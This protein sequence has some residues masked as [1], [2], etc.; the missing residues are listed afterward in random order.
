M[1]KFAA[2]ALLA[3]ISTPSFA[4]EYS[5]NTVLKRGE[6]V[7]ISTPSNETKT[8]K[9]NLKT[10]MAYVMEGT[11]IIAMSSVSTGKK[12]FET[13][14]GFYFI[15][16]KNKDYV[17]K[18]YKAPMPFTQW[19]DDDGIALHAGKIE[20]GAASHGCVRLPLAF[21]EKLFKITKPGDVVLVTEG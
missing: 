15:K 1:I 16:W 21:A 4:L 14:V 12:G 13:P 6:F 3:S 11:K 5:E 9:V 17:S 2:I 7:E 8:V 19:F 18:K 10:Q 20:A